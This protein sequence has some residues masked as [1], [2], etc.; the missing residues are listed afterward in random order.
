MSRIQ[1]VWLFNTEVQILSE[2]TKQAEQASRDV[3]P[4]RKACA[5]A[6]PGLLKVDADANELI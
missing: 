5:P 6:I 4:G 2:D 3:V 1:V